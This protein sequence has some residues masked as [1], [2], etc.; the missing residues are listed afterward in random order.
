MIR[1]RG[2][3]SKLHGNIPDIKIIQTKRTPKLEPVESDLVPNNISKNIFA[4]PNGS[5]ISA[6]HEGTRPYSCTVCNKTF[7][8]KTSVKDMFNQF[9]KG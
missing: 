9:M 6:V 8:L 5:K 4:I 3:I 1:I 2:H 7:D